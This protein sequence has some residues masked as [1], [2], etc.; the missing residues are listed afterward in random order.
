MADK[1]E[2]RKLDKQLVEEAKKT[3]P[4]APMEQIE[5]SEED[6]WFM[7]LTKIKGIGIERAKDIGRAFPSENALIGALKDNTVHFRNDVV[8]L[9]KNHFQLNKQED[10]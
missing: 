8:N 3:Q 4:E 7:E 5:Q 10:K 2:Y 1:D 9:L 6:K